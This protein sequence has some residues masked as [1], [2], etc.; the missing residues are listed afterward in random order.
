MRLTIKKLEELL[1]SKNIIINKIFTIDN[2]AVYIEVLC[3]SNANIFLLYIPSKYDVH[4]DS[5]TD[6]YKISYIE[7]DK[8]TNSVAKDYGEDLDKNELETTYNEIELQTQLS[9]D[10]DNLTGVLEEKYKR[11]ISLT[12]ITKKDKKDL[13]D[14]FRQ[15][16]RLKFCVQSIKYKLGI[17]YKNYLVPIRRDD[18]ID[19]YLIKDYLGKPTYSMMVIVDLETFYTSINSIELDVN[20]VQD[21]IY[22]ILDKNQNSHTQS[23]KDLLEREKNIAL[24]IDNLFNKKT[25]YTEYLKQLEQL[26]KST[27]QT[28]Q[29]IL[30][31]MATAKEKYSSQEQTMKTDIEKSHVL[32]RFKRDLEKISIVKQDIIKNIIEIKGKREDIFLV[33]D[34]F[35]FDNI[36]MLNALFS[37]I[38]KLTQYGK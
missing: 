35:L 15:L 17:V 14:I 21:G 24:N 29:K 18:S 23:F 34:N 38:N 30:E 3:I 1:G 27:N 11:P 25:Q 4:V 22:K 20:T 28:E 37:N 32:N 12:N 6:I 7:L 36:V 19:S 5:R 31:D 2:L 9:K 10:K 33:S 26:L 13:Q 16:E 8:L